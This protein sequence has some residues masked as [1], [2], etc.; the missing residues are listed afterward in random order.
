MSDFEVVVF[1]AL[2]AALLVRYLAPPTLARWRAWRRTP[3]PA[4][5]VSTAVQRSP[6]SHGFVLFVFTQPL[7]GSHE[8]SVHALPSLQS[9]STAQSTVIC[10]AIRLI[11]V[12]GPAA[13][14]RMNVKLGSLRK[15]IV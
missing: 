10:A 15:P 4:V 2:G 5:Q 6:S 7:P 8:S 14:S 1:G 12:M 11:G 13:T 9:A 3:A